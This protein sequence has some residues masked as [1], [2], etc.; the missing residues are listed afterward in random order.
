VR[1]FSNTWRQ[2]ASASGGT[3]DAQLGY[4]SPQVAQRIQHPRPDHG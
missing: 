1:Q 4:P 2:R 3:L